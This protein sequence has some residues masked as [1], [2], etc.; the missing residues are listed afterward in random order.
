M[1][2]PALWS[3]LYALDSTLEVECR[4]YYY[5]E[6][7]D[8]QLHKWYSGIGLGMK[9]NITYR[10]MVLV[11]IY[12]NPTSSI[13][14]SLSN[15]MYWMACLGQGD[16]VSM[17]KQVTQFEPIYSNGNSTMTWTIL[18]ILSP[19]NLN[20]EVCNWSVYCQHTP[21]CSSKVKAILWGEL[22]KRGRNTRYC[23]SSKKPYLK[24]VLPLKFLIK[25]ANKLLFCLF[26]FWVWF[27]VTYVWNILIQVSY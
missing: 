1:G 22:S 2:G 7:C 20:L 23:L 16:L 27:P 19:L 13:G 5:L 17:N 12:S 18:A 4:K 21:T 26:P 8:W 10:S 3:T 11:R 25:R 14:S 15:L 6:Y 24:P 9:H